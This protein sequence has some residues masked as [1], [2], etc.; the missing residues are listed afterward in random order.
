M[1]ELQSNPFVNVITEGLADGIDLS[2]QT[3]FPLSHL[4][5]YDA[6]PDERVVTWNVDLFCLDIVDVSDNGIEDN[7]H[8]V[9]NTQYNVGLRLFE[10]LKRGNLWDSG[11]EISTMKM[12]RLEQAFEN[13]LAGWRISFNVV[14]PN[15]MSIC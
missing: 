5:I 8:D 3:I 10:S 7:K 11:V 9:L 2:K 14:I 12:V 15:H 1:A 13:L 4:V 6:T